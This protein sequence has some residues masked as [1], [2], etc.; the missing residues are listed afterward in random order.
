MVALFH[1]GAAL[2]LPAPIAAWAS[3]GWLGVDAF[4]VLSGFVVSVLL[5]RGGVHA[6][7]FLARRL[8]RLL[9][10]CFVAFV[11]VELLDFASAHTPGFAGP[12]WAPSSWASL[13]CHATLSCAAFGLDWNNPVLWSLVVE[14]Q[15]YALAVALAAAAATGV[16]WRRHAAAAFAIAFLGMADDAWLERYLPSFALGFAAAAWRETRWARGHR[17]AFAAFAA[18]W[19]A[20]VQDVPVALVACAVGAMLALAADRRM[21]RALLLLGA[22]SYSFYLVHVPVGGRAVNLLARL[23]PG[24]VGAVAIVGCALVVSLLASWVLWRWVERPAI[25][26]SRR[27]DDRPGAPAGSTQAA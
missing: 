2:P 25:A 26:A 4:F 27:I 5:L 21:P 3:W 24:P 7:G 11:L 20:A 23:D 10:P 15:F 17:L 12:A 8:A 22:M 9:P 16:A 18:A 19:S 6:P 14:V 13:A 1:F